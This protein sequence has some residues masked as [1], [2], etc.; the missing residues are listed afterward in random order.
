ML[1][2][3]S[4]LLS[5]SPPI[6]THFT[7]GLLII[8]YFHTFHHSFYCLW[9]N[10]PQVHFQFTLTKSEKERLYMLALRL[11]IKYCI[12]FSAKKVFIFPFHILTCSSS[13]VFI[14]HLVCIA[15]PQDI[16]HGWLTAHS[17]DLQQQLII[18]YLLGGDG[19]LSYRDE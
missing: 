11:P 6:Y 8:S 9:K 12:S 5:V 3:C 4:G 1:S 10:S 14:N 13:S 17:A 16:C 18:S 15:A 19:S 2:S 7:Q